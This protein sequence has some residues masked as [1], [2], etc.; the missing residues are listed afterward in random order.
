MIGSATKPL[1]SEAITHGIRIQ[2]VPSFMDSHSDI[3]RGRFIFSYKIHMTNEGRSVFDLSVVHGKLLMQTERTTES[4]GLELSVNTQTWQSVKR[5]RIP[6]SV[7]CPQHGERWKDTF[8]SNARTNQHSRR[9]SLVSI[10][11]LR[12]LERRCRAFIPFD[13]IFFQRYSFPQCILALKVKRRFSERK[14]SNRW[15]DETD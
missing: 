9:R 2:V 15:V 7:H 4:T 12:R 6:V 14:R 1:G 10:S 8:S 5:S 13:E 3:E 11:P